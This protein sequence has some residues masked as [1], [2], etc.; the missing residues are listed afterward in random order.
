MYNAKKAFTDT[1]TILS[2]TLVV[3]FPD[4]TLFAPDNAWINSRLKDYCILA[5]PSSVGEYPVL[6][7]ANVQTQQGEKVYAM[8]H[9]L[10]LN[11]TFTSGVIS[12]YRNFKS[13]R[14]DSCHFIQTDTAINP[15][16]SG[17]PLIDAWGNLIGLITDKRIG[18][19]NLGFAITST[20]ILRGFAQKE[21]VTFPLTPPEIGP[22]VVRVKERH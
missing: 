8:G 18:A 13:D 10:D 5:V 20:E 4:G 14:G 11:Y 7:L 3:T 2:Y 21:L 12:G 16:N 15:G 9:P 6:N 17:G 22:F 1:P 19:E